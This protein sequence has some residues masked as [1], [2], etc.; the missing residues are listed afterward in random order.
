[1]ADKARRILAAGHSAIADAVFARPEERQSIAKIGTVKGLFLT[2]SLVTRIARIGGRTRD[3]SDADRSVAEAQ[4]EYD[5]GTLD[6]AEI[7]ASGTP[8]ETLERAKTAL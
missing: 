8:E 4:E 2:A 7:D 5:L 1:V 6:W 3:A